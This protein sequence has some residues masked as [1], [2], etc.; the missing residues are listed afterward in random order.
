MAIAFVQGSETTGTGLVLTLNGIT[1]GNLLLVSVAWSST[2]TTPSVTGITDNK[3]N[4]YIKAIAEPNTTNQYDAEFWYAKN[5]IGGNIT[6]TIVAN[7]TTQEASNRILEF[8]G[9]STTSPIGDAEGSTGTGVVPVVPPTVTIVHA[10]DMAVENLYLDSTCRT[11]TSPWTEMVTDS[12]FPCA[13][14][15]KGSAGTTSMTFTP[16]DDDAWV[17]AGIVLQAPSTSNTSSMFLVF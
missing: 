12:C 5:V 1:S 13:Y 17:S 2:I 8:S 11:A 4:T 9:C 10:T 16:A 15:I 7:T 6:V 14:Y 3:G